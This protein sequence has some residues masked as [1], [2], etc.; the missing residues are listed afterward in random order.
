MFGSGY[1]RRANW[2]LWGLCT[3]LTA[4]LGFGVELR[5]IVVFGVAAEV[6]QLG[7]GDEVGKVGILEGPATGP[8][9]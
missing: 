6:V 1:C 3:S 7:L 5:G 9:C 8:G 2:F 4:G